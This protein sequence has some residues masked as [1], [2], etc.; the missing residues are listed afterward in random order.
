ML[1]RRAILQIWEPSLDHSAGSLFMAHALMLLASFT[2]PNIV[3]QSSVER[4][5]MSCQIQQE[6]HCLLLAAASYHRLMADYI[7]CRN[8][9]VNKTRS[10]HASTTAATSATSISAWFSTAWCRAAWCDARM[11]LRRDKRTADEEAYAAEFPSGNG[12]GKD[13]DNDNTIGAWYCGCR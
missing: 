13:K 5:W 6:V 10:T 4:N 7:S 9:P 1:R 8:N 3:R 2:L 11:H 12:R